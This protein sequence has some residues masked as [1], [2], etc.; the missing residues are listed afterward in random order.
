MLG[1]GICLAAALIQGNPADRY[2]AGFNAA[3]EELYT[4]AIA[5]AEA[6]NWLKA[7]VPQFECPDEDIQRTYYFRWWTYRKHIRRIPDGWV[8][9]EFLPKVGWS[10]P[11]NTI[12][13]P[14]GH[15]F[16]EGRWIGK[17]EYLE[18]YAR[19]WF[20]A[21]G[22]T[23]RYGYST[24]LAYAIDA[25][26]QVHGNAKLGEE[27]LDGFVEHYRRW[28]TKP[29]LRNAWPQP[30]KVP[31]GGDGKGMFL[32]TDNCE[33]SEYSLS[34]HGYRP[35]F[36]SAMYAEAC[37]IAKLARRTGR[38]ALADEFAA[39]AA[40]LEKGIKDRVWNGARGFF[41]TR[42]E[43]GVHSPVRELHGYAPWY[44][45]MPLGAEYDTAWQW[46]GRA[47]GFNAPR[48]LTFPEQSAPG[49]KFTYE[50]HECQ[51]NG[52]SWPFATSI[53]LSALRNRLQN[54]A[55]GDLVAGRDTFVRL[56]GQY[57]AQQVRVRE[58]GVTVPWI[59][60]NY[61]PFSG[62]W[63]S[64]TVILNTPKMKA[65][66]PRERGKDYNHSVFCDLVISGLCGLVPQD[67][68]K[69]VVCPLAP[70]NWDW[71]CVEGIR[72]H[73]HELSI[74]FDRRGTRYG[75]GKGLVVLQDGVRVDAALGEEKVFHV[76]AQ[77]G[78]D[79]NPG[80]A[81]KPFATIRRA[82][83][84]VRAL[85]SRNGVAVEL[86]G[87]FNSVD[88]TILELG[89]NDGARSPFA[90]V[91]WRASKAGAIFSGACRVTAK[92]FMPLSDAEKSR[93]KVDARDKVVKCDLGKFGV[94]ELKPLPAK[95]NSWGEME[96]ISSGRAMTLARYPNQGWMEIT[97][98]ID[99]G[100][101]PCDRTKD[102]WEF[103]VR[104]GTFEYS[105]P[106]VERWDVSR[107]VYLF[108]FWCFDWASDTLRVAK[109]D[110]ERHTITMEGVHRYGLGKTSGYKNG[111]VRYFAYNM[112]EELDAPGEW[113]VDRETRT[114][115][116]YPDENGLSDVA[117]AMAKM[118]LVKITGAANLV[119]Q[120]LDIRYSTGR[121]AEVA[122][123]RSVALDGLNVSWITCSAMHLQGGS[124]C[125][126]RNCRISQVGS[127]GLSVV[128]GDRKSLAKCNHV[129][130]G[131]DIG[132]CGRLARISGP[133]LTFGGCGILVEHNYLHDTPYLTM[134]YGGNEHLIQYNEV[135][136][137][138]LEAGDG[139]GLYTGRDWGS[140]GN[141]VRWNYLHHF[142]KDGVELREAQGRPSGCEA[143]KQNVMVEGIYLDDCDSGETIY[144]NI[145]YKAGRAMFTGG[146]RDNHWR[147]NLVVDCSSAAHFD[148]RGLQRAKPGSGQKNGWDLLAKIEGFAYTNE[149]WASRY[150][151]LI[152]VMDKEP[153]LPIGTEYVSNVA[154]NCG[155]FF[156]SGGHATRFLQERAPNFAN[157]SCNAKDLKREL[158]EYP[159]TNA[160]L[161][162][163]LEVRTD[164]ELS[165][166]ADADPLTLQDTPAFRRAFPAFPRI[167]V[168]RIGIKGR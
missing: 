71:W 149:P 120:G 1:M 12:V 112:L 105:D 28:E 164:A 115:Y 119:V 6:A 3:D 61:H 9:T 142:G 23:K 50:G 58:D 20:S 30:G 51:W 75:K 145:F 130:R 64:R 133:C 124:D 14:A 2:V 19:F 18:A 136:C 155:Y 56:L 55:A 46:L 22:A 86:T 141:V 147:E 144:G 10:G 80:T 103:G 35:L 52:P 90:P 114:L 121:A 137:S 122:N 152:G 91:V 125:A 33:G 97:N 66:F 40:I 25:M 148:T 47:D 70:A 26:T 88:G 85:P 140:R 27:L 76:D 83:E 82:R 107:G 151:E 99:R 161:K 7:N 5:N 146:G 138:M 72:Y 21:E 42:A 106:A 45:G 63:I 65:R 37:T 113:Y 102:E 139:G 158:K 168:E 101:A 57:A 15:H 73:G 94:G 123:C 127:C 48:G 154:V 54:P 17:P 104:G 95:F 118:P 59:D 92:D 32:S 60:E 24:W 135:E 36:N 77:K 74:F 11:H 109:I 62:D 87:K 156:N 41:T 108:G 39:K 143:L 78:D 100:V 43:N 165:A 157:V 29:D 67:D 81:D 89:R 44:F 167:P 69:I 150:P 8:V 116:F 162:A 163:K 166:L 31:M 126:V 134:S 84:V 96:L 131:N 34:S 132:F 79:A 128:G 159:Q 16:M 153:L 117:L 160:V 111:K 93:L 98:V 68:G 38:T 129:V 49:F 110:H 4:N 53:A 13:C